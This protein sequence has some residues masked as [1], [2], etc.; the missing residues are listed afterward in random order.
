MVTSR[1]QNSLGL[2]AQALGRFWRVGPASKPKPAAFA[3]EP[4]PGGGR[5]EDLAE[6][7]SEESEPAQGNV[8]IG[9]VD[10][11]LVHGGDFGGREWVGESLGQLERSSRQSRGARR[12]A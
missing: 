6:T 5:G 4:G 11:H 8:A 9:L 2:G 7:L 3:D 1:C 10:D 12:Q